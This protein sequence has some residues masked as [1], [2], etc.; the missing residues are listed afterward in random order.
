MTTCVKHSFG[1]L[2][3]TC[4]IGKCKDC[5]E[6]T[7][8]GGFKLCQKCSEKLNRCYVC[9]KEFVFSKEDC[10]NVIRE[11]C[12]HLNKFIN[13]GSTAFHDYAKDGLDRSEKLINKL[14][15]GEINTYSKVREEVRYI[16]L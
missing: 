7:S 5:G 6:M 12:Q 4:D 13:G 8:C 10:I 11:Q 3:Y 14:E 9:G 2:C 16:N 15:S 1:G